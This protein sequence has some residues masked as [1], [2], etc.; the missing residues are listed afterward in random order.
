M[1]MDMFREADFDIS[2]RARQLDSV[3]PYL[4]AWIT[5]FAHEE[6][7]H[8]CMTKVT[9]PTKAYV[10]LT[11]LGAARH[12]YQA[13]NFPAFEA[14]E[15]AAMGTL[16]ADMT[17]ISQARQ[18]ALLTFSSMAVYYDESD[19]LALP[20]PMTNAAVVAYLDTA[21]GRQY[22][23]ALEVAI[24]TAV[25]AALRENGVLQYN[26]AYSFQ[27]GYAIKPAYGSHYS[28]TSKLSDEELQSLVS[29]A[30]A[31]AG[32]PAATAL[33]CAVGNTNITTLQGDPLEACL[34]SYTGR[35]IPVDRVL[36]DLSY[37]NNGTV[38]RV[39][40]MQSVINNFDAVSSRDN[41]STP[42]DKQLRSYILYV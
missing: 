14:A 5:L 39:G 33:T 6:A 20:V 12:A 19:P 42:F 25:Q 7:T 37:A 21:A 8:Q 9:Q 15:L 31:N 22:S 34:F 13:A 10:Y 17:A 4:F 41:R 11:Q 18:V 40:R 3:S 30:I 23:D 38:T 35:P 29:T 28:A 1:G 32:N 26:I 27:L 16:L 36:A 2:Y 24:L